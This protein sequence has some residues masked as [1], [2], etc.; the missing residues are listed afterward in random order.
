MTE[1]FLPPNTCRPFATHPGTPHTGLAVCQHCGKIVRFATW[2]DGSCEGQAAMEPPVR[3]ESTTGL[4]GVT[5]VPQHGT[6]VITQPRGAVPQSGVAAS[7][8]SG[9][10]GRQPAAIVVLDQDGVARCV[11]CD[12]PRGLCPYTARPGDPAHGQKYSR[13][14]RN[15]ELQA[16]ENEHAAAKAAKAGRP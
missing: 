12:R 15:C 13:A 4:C 10:E 9:K 5:I 2:G 8:Q 16:Q 7:L 1:R 14:A 11:R 3:N 6:V